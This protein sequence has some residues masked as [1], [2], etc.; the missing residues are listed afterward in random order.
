MT[1]NRRFPDAA[2]RKRH[3]R[4]RVTDKTGG[5]RRTESPSAR[6]CDTVDIVELPD[7][8]DNAGK[9]KTTRYSR[10]ENLTRS[11]AAKGI[12]RSSADAKYR[13]RG[14]KM[15]A[16]MATDLNKMD[17]RITISEVKMAD[18]T[19]R[20]SSDFEKDER[21][22]NGARV[23]TI[24]TEEER[25]NR[26]PALSIVRV[27]E[28]LSE[29]DKD[30]E[31]AQQQRETGRAEVPMMDVMFGETRIKALVDTGAQVTALSRDSYR[32]IKESGAPMQILPIRRFTLRGAFA[33]RGAPIAAKVRLEFTHKNARYIHEFYVVEKL[34]YDVVLGIDFLRQYRMTMTCD[35]QISLVFC[36]AA[37]TEAMINTIS[38]EQAEERLERL[39][40]HHSVQRRN[41]LREPLQA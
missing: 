31:K 25:R 2:V 32:R 17:D 16:I 6:D 7:S 26:D 34:T 39:V 4:N 41:W 18:D 22:E 20:H 29:L 13:E 1:A 40:E 11:G 36:E 12:R 24:V 28:I 14:R 23:E 5:W 37:D 21:M 15:A 10:N 8:D 35:D 27:K 3:T 38:V 33:E 30:L 9:P 19:E